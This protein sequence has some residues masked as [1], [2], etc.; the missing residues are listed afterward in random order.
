MEFL[1]LAEEH[2]MLFSKKNTYVK[3]FKILQSI[4]QEEKQTSNF[5][6][7]IRNARL[8]LEYKNTNIFKISIFLVEWTK[9]LI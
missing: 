9:I 3:Y 1:N 2:S 5:V 6:F 4:D 8:S 7:W